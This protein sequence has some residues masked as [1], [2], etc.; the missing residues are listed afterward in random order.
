[1]GWASVY[2]QYNLC[3]QHHQVGHCLVSHVWDGR[4]T[5]RSAS[6]TLWGKAAK[7][8][9]R[10]VASDLRWKLSTPVSS[11]DP[12]QGKSGELT[13]PLPGISLREIS[14]VA[15]WLENCSDYQRGYLLLGPFS[16]SL[17]GRNRLLGYFSV[18]FRQFLIG[19]FSNVLSEMGGS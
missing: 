3:C 10:P 11:T 19:D 12:K 17:A 1:M 13:I 5:P 7:H 6:F 9:H 16:E 15:I 18:R 14:S 4:P 8:L 2:N